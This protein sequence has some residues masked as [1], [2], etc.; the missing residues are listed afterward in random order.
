MAN[1]LRPV[2]WRSVCRGC[3]LGTTVFRIGFA[4]L[5]CPVS[6]V[7]LSTITRFQ[8]VVGTNPAKGELF[9]H[10]F[11]FFSLWILHLF[12]VTFVQL[13]F[14]NKIRPLVTPKYFYHACRTKRQDAKKKFWEKYCRGRYE[15]F[16]GRR[17]AFKKPPEQ[18][19]IWWKSCK[20][21]LKTPK[22]GFL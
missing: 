10:V 19:T 14:L 11:V 1:T 16:S 2:V 21:E 13:R 9:F 22:P 6:A 15:F 4:A 20:S 3:L 18:Q 12:W 8:K 7:S 17:S 5:F